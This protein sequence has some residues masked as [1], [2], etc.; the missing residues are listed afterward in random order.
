MGIY[1]Q[2]S[3]IEARVFDKR[4]AEMAAKHDS[5]RALKEQAE[6]IASNLDRIDEAAP[7]S[8][9]PELAVEIGKV[10]P[11]IVRSRCSRLARLYSLIDTH[12]QGGMQ[13][14]F[15]QKILWGEHADQS[16]GIE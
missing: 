12:M 6:F 10:L 5:E 4:D 16:K 8:I 1:E 7:A 13:K 9:S 15:A 14:K 2:A 11:E 3:E